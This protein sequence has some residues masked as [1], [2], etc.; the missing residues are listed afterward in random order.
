MLTKP[1]GHYGEN[2]RMGVVLYPSELIFAVFERLNIFFFFFLCISRKF[3]QFT[4]AKK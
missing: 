1:P 3:A 2:K 4:S